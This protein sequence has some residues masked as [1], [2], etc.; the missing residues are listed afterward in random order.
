MIPEI[1]TVR[2]SKPLYTIKENWF[3]KAILSVIASTWAFLYDLFYI[4]PKIISLLIIAVFFDFVTGLNSANR[5]NVPITSMG[6]RQTVVKVIEYSAFLFILTG[7]SNVFGHLEHTTH[8]IQA[9]FSLIEG[10]DVFGY[11]YLV[12][13]E[14]K[15]IAENAS[16]KTG[17]LSELYK[18]ILQI[19]K[20]IKDGED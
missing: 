8:W 14:L 16:G 12:M 15:S 3:V 20:P 2:Y 19:F 6:F 9:T 7:V 11:F 17:T 18:K 13:T 5:K 1:T 4:D 10:V